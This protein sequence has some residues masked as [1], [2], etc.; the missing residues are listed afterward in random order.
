MTAITPQTMSTVPTSWTPH[1]PP[2]RPAAAGPT[3]TP[4]DLMRII[5]QR[6]FLMMFISLFG[7]AATVGVAFFVQKYYPLYTAERIVQIMSLQPANP[8]DPL[9][10]QRTERPEDYDRLMLDQ[11]YL[12]VSPEVVT[13]TLQNPTVS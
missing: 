2:A 3:L 10:I 8:N 11:S 12:A 4:A 6:F 7:I 5:R 13:R 1:A 9:N